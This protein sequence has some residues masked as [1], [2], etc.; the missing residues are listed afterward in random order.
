MKSLVDTILQQLRGDRGWFSISFAS[1]TTEFEMI[2]H[3]CGDWLSRTL[4]RKQLFVP[5]YHTQSKQI[6]V[7][8]TAELTSAYSA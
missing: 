1:V 8:K 4:V 3:F 7:P 2:V 5:E 6:D